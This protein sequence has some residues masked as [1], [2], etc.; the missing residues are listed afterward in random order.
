MKMLIRLLPCVFLLIPRISNAQTVVGTEITDD[1]SHAASLRV[2]AKCLQH[3]E[4]TFT[5]PVN[6]RWR[7]TPEGFGVNFSQRG[8]LYDARYTYKGRWTGT[9]RYIPVARLDERIS[10]AVKRVFPHHNIFFAQ[11][12][13]V[14]QGS[15]Y[16]VKIERGNEW[17]LLHVVH[18][19]VTVVGEYVK[20]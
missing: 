20:S 17:K 3:F 18:R 10:A 12:L 15:I 11:Q 7:T 6:V 5:E 2:N 14:P 8:I 19:S 4:Q 1:N 9:I 13:S 16:V